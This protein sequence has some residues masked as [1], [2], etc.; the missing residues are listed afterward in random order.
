MTDFWSG[1]VIILT[2]VTLIGI[3]WILFATR[4]AETKRGETTGHEYDGIAE[5]DNPMPAWWIQ[6]FVGTLVFGVVYLI[7]Y[8]GMG[9]YK[10]YW[11]WTS[12]GQWQEEV[13]TMEARFDKVYAQFADKSIEELADDST[14]RAMGARLFANNCAV[15]HGADGRGAHGFPN[16][17]DKDWLYGGS[18]EQIKT[19]LVN[20]RNGAM[21]G[22]LNALGEQGIDDVAQHVL[23]LSGAAE[24]NA[25]GAAKYAQLCSACHGSDANG[26]Q[27]LGAPNLTDDIWLYGGDLGQVKHTL[28]VGRNGQMPAQK[29]VISDEKIHLLTAYVYG[30]SK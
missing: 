23:S 15:C 14:A 27:I 24:A 8:P 28:R 3:T 1:W 26:N 13:E 9:N 16:L 11:N 25:N 22:W 2:S 12:H 29:G 17:T 19:T 4:K 20:G 21:P 6:L 7:L 5:Y 30:L 18:P 10:G